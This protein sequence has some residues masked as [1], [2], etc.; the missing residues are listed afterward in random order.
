[1]A[2]CTQA[3][4]FSTYK[5]GN[6]DVT[7]YAKWTIRTYKVQFNLMK[8]E[9]SVPETSGAYAPKTVN[10][11]EAVEMPTETPT[12]EYATFGGWYMDAEYT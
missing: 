7:L 10:S 1:N 4:D 8:T 5:V 2:A 9:G 3:I 6:S 11:G 12:K